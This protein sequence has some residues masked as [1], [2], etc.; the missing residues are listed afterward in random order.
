MHTQ[1]VHTYGGAQTRRCTRG[2]GNLVHIVHIRGFCFFKRHMGW[3]VYRIKLVVRPAKSA[4]WNTARRCWPDFQPESS[5]AVSAGTPQPGA[6]ALPLA[7]SLS[8]EPNRRSLTAVP[9][10]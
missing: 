1:A 7:P 4:G 10:Q 2:G 9:F 3:G 5:V 8:A 6:S